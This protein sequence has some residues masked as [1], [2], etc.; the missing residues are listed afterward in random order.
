MN[1]HY[2][3]ISHIP[4]VHYKNT[5]LV[6]QLWANDLTELT[7][8]VGPIALAAPEIFT[9]TT[10][11]TWGPQM[12]PLPA[13][14]PITRVGLPA[15]KH[16]WDLWT[17]HKI[18]AILKRQV[19]QAD[20]VHSS[21]AFHPYLGLLDAHFLA[22]KLGKKTLFVVA[23]DYHDSLIWEW[24]RLSVNS[25]QRFRRD[26]T[27]R[28]MDRLMQKAVAVASLTFL[29]TPA[30]V[31]RFRL[32][33][34]NAIAVRDTTHAE[35][36]I[37]KES[38]FE[39]KCQAI[40]SGE[41]LQIIAASRHK[42]LKGLEFIVRAVAE[43]KLRGVCVKANIFGHG[44][45][46]PQL[47]GLAKY[48]KVDDR[49]FFPGA[50]PANQAVYEALAAHHISLMPHRTNEFARALYDAFAGGTPV[51]AF[52]TP[53]SRGSV[54]DGVD[55]MLVPLDNAIGLAVAVER[56]HRN[57]P[58]LTALCG[59]ARDRAFLETRTIWHKFRADLIEELFHQAGGA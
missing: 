44:P 35:E 39:K 46:T 19:L 56:L 55:G 45:L 18:Y 29:F 30:A 53:A 52:D 38:A 8:H 57:R 40:L 47:E 36:D 58:L 37:I 1:R 33:A 32:F 21:N 43:L 50:L 5:L 22:A 49:V 10:T 48:L 27:V 15:M 42:P 7:S 9:P 6:D 17:K 16:S 13:S 24:V 11:G 41:P 12:V 4:F 2:L 14:L 25:L 26:L 23:E 20:L 54:R 28:H 34:A 51:V 59:N 31:Q 3:L